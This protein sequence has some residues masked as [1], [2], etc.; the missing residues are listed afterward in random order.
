MFVKPAPEVNLKA[1][2]HGNAWK[3]VTSS[4]WTGFSCCTAIPSSFR[5]MSEHGSPRHPLLSLNYFPE[6]LAMTDDSRKTEKQV[7]T[8]CQKETKVRKCWIYSGENQACCNT[9]EAA[10]PDQTIVCHIPAEQCS[11]TLCWLCTA[12]IAS[13]LDMW[14]LSYIWPCGSELSL[15]LSTHHIPFGKYTHLKTPATLPAMHVLPLS[16]HQLQTLQNQ[17]WKKTITACF[18]YCVPSPM[19]ISN[20]RTTSDSKQ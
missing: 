13:M 2:S 19:I 14:L 17:I 3:C 9:S 15:L 4:P 10:R 1:D 18:P 16:C 12:C 11:T 5:N 7:H 6:S 20:W 8:A